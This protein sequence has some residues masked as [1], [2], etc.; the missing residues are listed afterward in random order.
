MLLWILIGFAT[1][2]VS[3]TKSVVTKIATNNS[4]SFVVTLYSRIGG[5]LILAPIVFL[6]IGFPTD[7]N[8]D[9]IVAVV[10]GGVIL[11]ITSYCVTLALEYEDLSIVSPLLS[12][13]PAATIVPSIV[14]V[15][16]T[17][18]VG[19]GFGVLLVSIGAYLLNLDDK[20][21]SLLDPIWAIV[22]S[23]GAQYAIVAIILFASVP[24]LNKI[25]LEHTEPIT[26]TAM[27]LPISAIVLSAIGI[28]NFGTI[29]NEINGNLKYLSA[30]AVTTALL[31]TFQF[32]GYQYTQVS[33]IQAIKQFKVIAAITAGYYIFDEEKNIRGRLT[34]GIIM[35]IGSVLVI[36]LS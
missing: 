8:Q 25:A 3:A 18:T 33:Y 34:G 36:L 1:A 22:H 6:L 12:F 10:I 21:N 4:S 19:A 9:V 13:V 2:G 5:F 31:F 11:S 32:T 26:L 35:V 28:R 15:G 29:R 27:Q 20:E 30:V 17:P 23:R 16:E 14:I 24:S 7:L